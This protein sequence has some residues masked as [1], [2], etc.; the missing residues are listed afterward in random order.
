MF[1]LAFLDNFSGDLVFTTHRRADIDGLA[2]AIALCE[3][4]GSGRIVIESISKSGKA[5]MKRIGVDYKLAKIL[6]ECD[7]CIIVD[8]QLPENSGFEKFP[9]PLGII[10]HHFAVKCDIDY[11]HVVERPSCAEILAEMVTLTD[12]S[13]LALLAGI[14]SD[15]GFFRFAVSDTLKVAEVLSRRASLQKAQELVYETPARDKRLA[16][17]KA[18]QRAKIIS[19]N[20][21][22][23]TSNI[24]SSEAEAASAL[25]KMGADVAIVTSKRDGFTRTSVRSRKVGLHFGKLMGEFAQTKGGQGGG[26]DSAATM[27]TPLDCLDDFVA[28]VKSELSTK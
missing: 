9:R 1:S 21:L 16:L 7:G 24:G 15:T 4:F 17:I 14:L 27:N 8:S 28:R 25:V 20:P 10:D 12:T 18:S 22:I 11:S 19:T 13:A 23:V 5:F 6:P 3:H 26:H 2:S